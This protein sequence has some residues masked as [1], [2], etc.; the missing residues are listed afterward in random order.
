M[1]TAETRGTRAA[2][3]TERLDRL[4]SVWWKRLL[5]VQRPYRWNLRRLRLGFVLDVGCGIGRNLAHL[6]GNG[7]GVDHN[8]ASVAGARRRGLEAYLPDEFRA[9]PH[10]TAGR[11]DALLLAHVVEHM[12]FDEAVALL[13]EYQPFV[14]AG[15][16]VVVIC[17]QEAG[18]RSDSTHVEFMPPEALERLARAVGLEPDAAYSFPFPRA[19]GKVFKH[20]ESVM[21][22]R[23]G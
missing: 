20:N 17:P 14:R 1:A 18:F 11:F 13:R 7:V 21:V 10:A 2:A 22:G 8:D 6:E 23:R 19:A 5:D 3:Y 4:S 15:G 12:R 16:R 9:S